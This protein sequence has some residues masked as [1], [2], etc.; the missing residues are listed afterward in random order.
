MASRRFG[1]WSLVAGAVI[2]LGGLLLQFAVIPT[3]K[4][5]PEDVERTRVYDGTLGVLLNA[6]ALANQDLANVF[7]RDVP[8]TIE[9]DVETEQVDG[10]KAI[11][12]D[13]SVL[14]GPAGPIQT[15]EDIYA[16]DRKSMEA[17]ADFTDDDRVIDREGLVVGFPIGTDQSDYL[18]FNGDTLTTNTL[19]YVG[20]SEV[21]GL[22]T[23]EFSAASGPDVITDP[24]LLESFPPA[25]PQA[26]LQGL[27][28]ALGLPDE[29]VGQLAGLLPSLPDPVPLTYTYAYDTSY[30]VEPDTGM[31][32]DY[33]KTEL[34]V[35]N[36]SVGDQLVPVAEVMNLEYELSDGSTADAISEAE[37]AKSQ[38]FWLG[39]VLPWATMIIGAGLLLLGALAMFLRR[40]RGN[41][42]TAPTIDVTGSSRT[43]VGAATR[44]RESVK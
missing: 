19:S 21:D 7:I 11:V 39:Q 2:L 34:R 1:T 36:L 31:L 44:S 14:N 15:S 27:L 30:Q 4:Q 33:A 12:S 16:I 28:P 5:F 3:L 8:I 10:S 23:Y 41:G 35:V 13:V 32:I 38:L 40:G 26:M 18:G 20:T 43:T 9:R 6:D 22:A 42:H 37:D 25:L 24:V 17:V 29:A